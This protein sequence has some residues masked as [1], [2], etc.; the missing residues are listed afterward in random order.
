MTSDSKPSAT[1]KKFFDDLLSNGTDEEI[2][3]ILS[4]QDNGEETVD[5]Y[6]AQISVEEIKLHFHEQ[7]ADVKFY[8]DYI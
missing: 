5:N 6:L 2:K 3:I 4:Q 7:I 1:L 8:M